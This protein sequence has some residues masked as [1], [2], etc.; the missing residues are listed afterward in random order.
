VGRLDPRTNR[1][2]ALDLPPD[3]P[4]DKR[5]FRYA[6]RVSVGERWTDEAVRRESARWVHVPSY[7]TRLEDERRLLVYL[8]RRWGQSRVWRSSAPDEERTS[9]S[10]RPSQRSAPSAVAG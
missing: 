9:S 5:T 4:A 10:G 3:G 8:P 6:H 7:G 2:V 1:R